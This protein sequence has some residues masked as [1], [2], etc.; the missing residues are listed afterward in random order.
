MIDSLNKVGADSSFKNRAYIAAKNGINQYKG[1][2]EQNLKML[3]L[4][5]AGKLIK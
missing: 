2:A 3:E 5:N 4:L 1:T